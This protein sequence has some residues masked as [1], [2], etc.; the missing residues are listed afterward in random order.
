MCPIFNY[1]CST[2]DK[3]YEI[4]VTKSDDVVL[5]L[6]CERQLEKQFTP[7]FSGFKIKGSCHRNDYNA[8]CR[9]PE[10]KPKK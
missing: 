6:Q 10:E 7:S 9:N 5:C 2:C 1:Y 8:I 3:E 4:R